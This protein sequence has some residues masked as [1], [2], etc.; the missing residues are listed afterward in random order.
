MTMKDVL[1]LAHRLPYPPNKGDKIRS[2]NIL[3]HL[4]DHYRVHLGCF[5]DDPSDFAYVGQLEELCHSSCIRKLTPSLA[6][7]KS[8]RGF[9]VGEALSVPY[10]HDRQLARWVEDLLSERNVEAVIGYSSPMAQYMRAGLAG[11]ARRV[12]DFVD[13]DSDKWAQYATKAKWP[14]RW[15][16]SREAR[17]L[18]SYEKKI[19]REFDATVFVSEGESQTFLEQCGGADGK[20]HAVRNGVAA[21][22]FDPALSFDSPFETDIKP[23]VFTGMMNYWPNEDATKW[24][25]DQVF[26]AV[27]ER[28]KDAEFWIV[29]ASPTRAVENLAALPGVSVTGRVE[30]VRPYIQHAAAV[31]APLRIA[32]GVQ[33]KVLEA[34]AMGKHVICSPEAAFGLH[35]AGQVP[36]SVANSAAEFGQRVCEQLE[37]Q[38][39]DTAQDGAAAR[40]Y[41]TEHY[42]WTSNLQRF[43]Q[44]L[45]PA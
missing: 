2:F 6:K 23:I 7:L 17:L 1:F 5:V 38:E 37:A 27:R 10:Y 12:I 30:D 18:L 26:P 11:S 31:V 14:M 21:E 42:D 45:S 15:I 9:L 24:F 43:V 3:R 40:A 44:L 13:I 39:N 33:N 32:R 41:V 22:Y 16:Y 8:L 20:I 36:F 35:A 34:L 29:G 4:A 19:A 25:A 28:H